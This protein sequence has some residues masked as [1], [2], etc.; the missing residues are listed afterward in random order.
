LETDSKIKPQ[1]DVRVYGFLRPRKSEWTT[2]EIT[3][4]IPEGAR[5]FLIRERNDRLFG[6]GFLESYTYEEC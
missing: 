1:L 4:L 5:K 6:Y 3:F 2:P